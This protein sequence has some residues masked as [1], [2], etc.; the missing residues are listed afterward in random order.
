ECC[1]QKYIYKPKL[2]DTDSEYY[3]YLLI[4]IAKLNLQTE[5]RNYER[6]KEKIKN[7][8]DLNLLKT[9]GQIDNKIENSLTLTTT[10]KDNLQKKRLEQKRIV[11]RYNNLQDNINDKTQIT[12]DTI[13]PNNLKEQLNNIHKEHL[14]LLLYNQKYNEFVKQIRNETGLEKLKNEWIRK[15]NESD[16]TEDDKQSLHKIQEKQIRELEKDQPGTNDYQHIRREHVQDLSNNKEDKQLLAEEEK[17]DLLI[18]TLEQEYLETPC[19]QNK[20]QELQQELYLKRNFKLNHKDISTFSEAFEL[21]LNNVI[22]K[23]NV[24]CLLQEL[25]LGYLK[26]FPHENDDNKKTLL[27]KIKDNLQEKEYLEMIDNI[28][29]KYKKHDLDEK[30]EEYPKKPKIDDENLSKEEEDL[31]KNNEKENKSKNN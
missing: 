3:N 23:E 6:L 26:V 9:G 27:E 17:Y 22:L 12:I 10:Q 21:L 4:N 11:Q 28:L 15:I 7:T 14:S 31:S 8:F 19:E 25:L 30:E 24:Y 2:F 13:L 20:L 16:F 29:S 5:N 18:Q 1:Y